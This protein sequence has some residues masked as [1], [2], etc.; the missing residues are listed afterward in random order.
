MKTIR[1]FIIM[2]LLPGCAIF[3]DPHSTESPPVQINDTVTLRIIIGADL[4]RFGIKGKAASSCGTSAG[5]GKGVCT[6]YLPKI[7]HP[8]DSRGWCTYGVLLGRAIF[9]PREN[10]G[11][12]CEAY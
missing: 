11:M 6:L 12:E 3:T 2:I 8:L 4:N 7:K 9:G 5:R 10:E 1:L